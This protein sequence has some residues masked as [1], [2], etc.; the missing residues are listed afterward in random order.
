MIITENVTINDVQYKYTKS[1][2]G[3]YIQRNDGKQFIDAYDKIDST[4]TYIELTSSPKP[5]TVQNI[6][7]S[8]LYP[9]GSIYIGTMAVC[10]LEVLGIG[11]WELKSKGR[12]LQGANTEAPGTTKEAGLPN[13]TDELINHARDYNLNSVLTTSGRAFYKK[14]SNNGVKTSYPN[15]GANSGGGYTG[16]KVIGFDLSRGNNIYGKSDTVQPPAYIVN[17]W[18]RIS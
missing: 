12:V 5:I 10:P 16:D 1:S 8:Q 17:I 15:I 3:Y 2:L 7:F 9:I 13:V 14:S 18:E 11:V 4:F 6:N